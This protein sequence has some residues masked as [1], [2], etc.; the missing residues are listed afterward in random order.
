MNSDILAGFEYNE[1][2][3]PIAE[4][5]LDVLEEN[6]VLVTQLEH[7]PVAQAKKHRL[8]GESSSND[9]HPVRVIL[10]RA[11]LGLQR[12]RLRRFR[13]PLAGAAFTLPVPW[14]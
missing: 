9:C 4:S 11:A 6:Y 2:S 5:G 12:D 8:P 13:L 1:K 3:F 10:D 7:S 14:A